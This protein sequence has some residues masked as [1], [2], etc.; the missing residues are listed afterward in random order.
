MRPQKIKTVYDGHALVGVCFNV[1]TPAECERFVKIMTGRKGPVERDG[2]VL[3]PGKGVSVLPNH[4]SV[5]SREF[6]R[7]DDI[8]P[9]VDEVVHRID[10]C[11]KH[12]N[13]VHLNFKL[14]WDKRLEGKNGRGLALLRYGKTGDHFRAHQDW[15]NWNHMAARRLTSLLQLSPPDS[16]RGS[17]LMLS[18]TGEDPIPKT[19]GSMTVFPSFWYHRV[20]PLKRGTR[21]ALVGWF[22]GKEPLL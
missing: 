1:L 4:R 21:Y 11:V 16:Y 19:Q 13:K 2:A 18:V 6:G 7:N 20:T 17:R 8:H 9:F 14:S 12:L 10:E 3:S 15:G 22:T 5:K